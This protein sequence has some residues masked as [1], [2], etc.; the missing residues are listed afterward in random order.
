[1]FWFAIFAVIA[2][3]TSI[4]LVTPLLLKAQQGEQTLKPSKKLVFFTALCAIVF[5]LISLNELFFN[6]VDGQNFSLFNVASLASVITATI[7]T[8]SI[9]RVTTLW[10][11]LP[12]IYSFAI[13]NII[14]STFFPSH[15]IKHLSENYGLLGHITLALLSYAVFFITTLYALQLAWLDRN[16]KLKRIAVSPIIPPLMKV[17]K[18]FFHLLL[19]AEI[20]LAVTLLTGCIYLPNFFS[21]DQI[22]KAILSFIAWIIFAILLLGHYTLHWRGKKVIIYTLSGMIILTLAYFGSRLVVVG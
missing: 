7:V 11:L 14:G 19:I 12:V 4:L 8:F 5:H 9:F 20:L 1:M 15:F 18:Q 10:L 3:V 6:V 17:E 16:L 2:Y 13:I 21:A 22:Q